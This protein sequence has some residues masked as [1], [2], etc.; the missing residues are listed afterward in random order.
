MLRPLIILSF[1][2]STTSII[3]QEVIEAL[4]RWMTSVHLGYS[5]PQHPTTRFLKGEQ[6]SYRIEAQY[7]VKYNQPFLAGVYYDESTLSRYVLKYSQSSGVGTLDIKEKANTRRLEPGI[8]AGFYPEVN[9]LLQPYLQGRFGLSI[10]QTSSILTDRDTDETIERISEFTTVAPAYGLD[11]GVHIVP[12]LWYI[13]GD[14][15]IGY[16]GNTSTSYLLYD[17]ESEVMSDYP[18]DY[19]KLYTSAGRWL[20]VS[21]GISHLP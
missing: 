11:L 17:E 18:I 15:R 5:I 20:R 21:L 8:T 9:W 19:F 14:V 2:F 10:F 3:A 4:P 7:R 12:N 16:A 6:W 13:R 1:I